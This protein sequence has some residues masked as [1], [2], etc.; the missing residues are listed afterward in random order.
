M[1]NYLEHNELPSTPLL[2]LIQHLNLLHG[3]IHSKFNVPNF[4]ELWEVT[5]LHF[6]SNWQV[7]I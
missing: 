2:C 6:I 5:S 3:E 4:A 1:M 7:L